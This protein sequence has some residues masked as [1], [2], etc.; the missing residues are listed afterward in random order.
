MWI[1]PQW[2]LINH[3]FILT[4]SKT[5][6]NLEQWLKQLKIANK[7]VNYTFTP[8]IIVSMYY[9][10]ITLLANGLHGTHICD[11]KVSWTDTSDFLT[12]YRTKDQK[13]L[14][15]TPCWDPLGHTASNFGVRL[16]IPTSNAYIPKFTITLICNML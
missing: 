8:R 14:Y 3:H 16:N 12:N 10:N 2:P 11:W 9:N 7:N 6:V 4:S 15:K 13:C 5:H 1:V